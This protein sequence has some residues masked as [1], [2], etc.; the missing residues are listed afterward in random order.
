MLF[1]EEVIFMLVILDQ[2]QMKK[3]MNYK[4]NIKSKIIHL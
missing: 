1:Q 2:N 3:I 4:Y